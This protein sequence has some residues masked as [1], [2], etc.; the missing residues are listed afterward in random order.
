METIGTRVSGAA[1]ATDRGELNGTVV[2]AHV[3]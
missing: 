2:L 3:N 1:F